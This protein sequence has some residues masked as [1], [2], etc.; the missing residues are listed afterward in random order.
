MYVVLLPP[1]AVHQGSHKAPTQSQKEG[2][3]TP[4]LLRFDKVLEEYAGPEIFTAAIFK[5]Y[6]PPRISLATDFTLC[7]F[8]LPLQS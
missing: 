3:S 6:I 2:K 1:H 7:H 5:K 8:L 4:C